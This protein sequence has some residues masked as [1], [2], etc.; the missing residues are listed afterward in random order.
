MNAD[1]ELFLFVS[2][3]GHPTDPL[4]KMKNYSYPCASVFIRGQ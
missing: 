2:I 3:W 1:E 4:E